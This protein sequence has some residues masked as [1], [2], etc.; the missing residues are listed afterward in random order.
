[1][2]DLRI[3]A[4]QAER[5]SFRDILVLLADQ[6]NPAQASR[7]AEAPLA[8]VVH[9]KRKFPVSKRPVG[10][11]VILPV[12]CFLAVEEGLLPSSGDE[13]GHAWNPVRTA[14]DRVKELTYLDAAICAGQSA[15]PATIGTRS[16]ESFC[17]GRK[18]HIEV[19]PEP[20]D[21]DNPLA[22]NML[23]KVLMGSVRIDDRILPR[24]DR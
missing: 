6:L 20:A 24:D 17:R 16:A 4:Q 23:R 10:A 8:A 3:S 7:V 2:T 14:C 21:L 11:I 9:R 13:A 22:A 12:L 5:F 1:M 19:L 15:E 18:T